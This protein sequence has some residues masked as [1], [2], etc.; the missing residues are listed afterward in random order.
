MGASLW[1]VARRL[2]GNTGGFIAL[3]LYCFSP[4]LIQATAVWHTE[5]E[6]ARSLG[7]FRDHLH[8]H[9]RR[10][11]ALR[12]ARSR[13]LELAPHRA[14]RSRTRDRHRFAVLHDRPGPAGARLP[15]LRGPR[16]PAGRAGHLARVLP[17]RIRSPVRRVFLPPSRLRRKPAPRLLLGR[18]PGEASPSRVST[19]RSRPRS[20]ALVRRSLSVFRSRWP[21]TLYGRARATSATPLH[22]W[23]PSCSCFS[24]WHTPTSLVPDSSSPPFR[25][26][27]SSSPES[28]PTCSRRRT[29]P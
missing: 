2:C 14:P 26:S 21:L 9:R 23:S 29:A 16:P 22:S 12:P 28:S 6:I 1:Y 4:S 19:S 20:A 17:G 8:R 10:P 27:S 13:A 3:T 25:S 11:H 5:P 18:P 15:A 24:A 7:I